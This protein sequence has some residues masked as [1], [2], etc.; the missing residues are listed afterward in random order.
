MPSRWQV[1]QKRAS[2]LDFGDD[3]SS[4][5]SSRSERHRL[6]CTVL[7]SGTVPYE[8]DGVSVHRGVRAIG[9]ET[10]SRISEHDE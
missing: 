10:V 7:Q 1:T 5:S 9:Q 8:L 4:C 2:W 6:V 3:Q